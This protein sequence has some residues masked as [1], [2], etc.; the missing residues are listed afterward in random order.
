MGSFLTYAVNADKVLVHVEDVKTGLKC[1]CF[2]PYCNAPLY[3]KNAG[4]IRDHHFAHAQGH[5][6]EGAYESQ[7]HL[8]AKEVL[9]ECGCIHLPESYDDHHPTGIV[10]LHN[11]EV[12]KYDSE[13]SIKPDLEGVMDNGERLLVEF[14]VSHKVS[15]GKRHKIVEYNLQ[16]IEI[17]IKYQ[18]LNKVDLQK[19]LTESSE[20][21]VWIE[22][23]VQANHGGVST[24]SRNP[25]YN[26]VRDYLKAK[27]DEKTLII[28]PD[29][30]YYLEC[31]NG[32][33]L[34][35]WGYDMCIVNTKYHGFKTDLLLYRSKE[36]DKGYISINIRGRKRSEEFR[37]PKTYEYLILC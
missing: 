19:F 12:E 7:L 37:H 33:D 13:L 21:R 30:K 34:K 5:E 11:I 9:M 3:P 23:S 17:D 22:P 2:C 24:S 26:K 15:R 36:R 8:F 27:F 14:V 20:C 25:I 16:C 31:A 18:E 32:Y 6:C 28:Y 1:G 10:N 4:E 35:H 29:Y